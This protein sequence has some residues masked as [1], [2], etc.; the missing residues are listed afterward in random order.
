MIN[1][2][3]MY[4]ACTCK[5]YQREYLS[6][7][8]ITEAGLQD[9]ERNVEPIVH[10]LFDFFIAGWRSGLCGIQVQFDTRSVHLERSLDV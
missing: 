1:L 9:L 10:I 4:K 2:S 6:I 7:R 3:A 5:L 8:K